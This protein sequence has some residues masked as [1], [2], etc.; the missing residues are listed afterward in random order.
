MVNGR[1]TFP[2]TPRIRMPRRPTLTA[3]AVVR[4]LV[5]PLVAAVVAIT[6]GNASAAPPQPKEGPA[7]EALAPYQPQFF[8]RHTVEP[9]V[10][11]FERLVLKAY[12]K[13]HSD[14]DMRGCDDGATS[15]HKDGRAWDWG[16]DHR[17]TAQRKAGKAL[18]KWLFATDSHGNRYAMVRRLGIMYIIW[19]HRIWGSWDTR[20]EPYTDC[21]GPTACHVDHIHFSF[22][23]AGAE[24]KTSYWTHKVSGDV[25][26]PL[27]VLHK[28]GKH[29]SLTV[30]AASG[31]TNAMW[32]VKGGKTYTVTASGTWHHGTGKKALSD[33]VCTHTSDGWVRSSGVA[34]ISGDNLSPWEEQWTPVHDTGN[35]C[36]TATHTYRM[37]LRP[38][39]SSTVVGDLPDDSRSNDSGHITL[40]V[41][42]G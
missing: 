35:G 25:E 19:N 5:V 21:S 12:P 17:V 39:T 1:T 18:L 29:R 8:C 42:V 38:G 2:P 26:P 22:D 20:W 6:V 14:G 36:N 34:D 4:A 15:E 11:A 24:K 28:A 30:S 31:S 41:A 40:R 32:L 13:T 9:G 33:A 23:W 37:T 16:A 3:T 7:I 10:T 27:P